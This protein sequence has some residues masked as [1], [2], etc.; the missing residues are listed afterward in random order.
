MS[1]TNTYNVTNQ[2]TQ[3]PG[4]NSENLASRIVKKLKDQSDRDRRGRMFDPAM[5]GGY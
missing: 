1:Q 4:E 3:R 5:A 2:I